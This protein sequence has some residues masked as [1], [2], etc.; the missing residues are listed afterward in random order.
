MVIT[1]ALSY[2]GAGKGEEA[3]ELLDLASK[4][5]NTATWP[6]QIISHLRGDITAD[7]LLSRAGSNND[8]LTE[9]HAYI[10]MDLLL[11][12]QKDVAVSHFKWVIEHG[13]RNFVEYKLAET[14]LA[15]IGNP[16]LKQ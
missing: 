6:Y 1:G 8:R 15:R 11:K 7:E 16:N 3:K 14:Q 13:N 9:A 12:E 2:R 4:R 5:S 10:A